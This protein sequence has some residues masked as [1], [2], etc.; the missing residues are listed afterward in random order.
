MLP[1]APP[2]G[3]YQVYAVPSPAAP[4]NIYRP[5][6]PY[7]NS[8]SAGTTALPGPPPT[9]S[10]LPSAPP[11]LPSIPPTPVPPTP[12]PPTPVPPVLIPPTPLSYGSSSPLMKLY[13]HIRDSTS[14]IWSEYDQWQ[15]YI[16]PN[17]SLYWTCSAY[18]ARVVSDIKPPLSNLH[19]TAPSMISRI[20]HALGEIPQIKDYHNW[21]IYTNGSTCVYIDHGSR[22]ASDAFQSLEDF[23]DQ[24]E[25]LRGQMNI[26]SKLR[27]ESAYW[28]FMQ[29]HPNHRDLPDGA[30][31]DAT[32][33]VVWCHADRALFKSSNAPF[34]QEDA[35]EMTEL[36]K[37]VA[38]L[39]RPVL[40]TWYCAAI[41][42]AIC[43]DR[44]ASHYG[45][46][47]AREVRRREKAEDVGSDLP[48]NSPREKII[49]HF[50]A[51]LSLGAPLRYLKRI[52]NVDRTQTGDGVNT[53]RWRVFL[54]S[55]CKE[56]TDSNLLATVL[57][58]ATV[59]LLA[60]PDLNGMSRIAGVI[61]ALY[62]L[63]SVLCGMLLI[64]N[65]QDRVDSSGIS[66]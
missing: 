58:S 5:A 31:D 21:E 47:D 51:S 36:M 42:R 41:L 55:L 48:Y 62:A 7:G 28:T 57:V 33:A 23:R 34:S 13:G 26:K 17:G 59:A 63:S 38:D 65:H 50:V 46:N 45:Q 53:L 2:M 15:E 11:M 39:N 18:P 60:I 19:T 3:N 66:G 12:V 30:I 29:S 27:L 25:R 1:P 40:K 8:N 54:K 16:H 52:N 61:S 10:T 35:R 14:A 43:T 32:E 49:W 20:M 22:A 37:T 44:I 24:V 64:S 56:W 6:E 9:G 4:T